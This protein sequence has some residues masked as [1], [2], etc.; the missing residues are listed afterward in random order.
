MRRHYHRFFH[1]PA[2]KITQATFVHFKPEYVSNNKYMGMD[3]AFLMGIVSHQNADGELLTEPSF[4]MKT[5][6]RIPV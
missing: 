1:F 2:L 3:L 5:Y 6:C 4:H